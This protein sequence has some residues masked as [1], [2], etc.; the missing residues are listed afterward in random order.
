MHTVGN[1]NLIDF[2]KHKPPEE[3]YVSSGKF[4]THMV[5]LTVTPVGHI[6]VG[7]HYR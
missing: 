3:P 6:W 4:Q 2:D 7:P 5:S 1:M